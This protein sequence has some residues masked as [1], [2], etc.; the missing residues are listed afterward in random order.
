MAPFSNRMKFFNQ[1]M[2]TAKP[3][4]LEL[5][6]QAKVHSESL[7]AFVARHPKHL[8]TV[9]PDMRTLAVRGAVSVR[10]LKLLS[11]PRVMTMR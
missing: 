4:S 3:Y 7:R 11:V 10:T 6:A 1:L 9:P 5:L 2:T 8:T